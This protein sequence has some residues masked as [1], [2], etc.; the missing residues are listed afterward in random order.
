MLS[1]IVQQNAA[2]LEYGARVNATWSYFTPSWV[3]QHFGYLVEFDKLHTD[4]LVS[5]IKPQ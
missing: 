1:E 4:I 2:I 5:V 3:E